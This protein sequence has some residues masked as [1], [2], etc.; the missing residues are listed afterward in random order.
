MI[1]ERDL[2]SDDDA[3]KEP[4]ARVRVLLALRWHDWI[5]P[6]EL[7]DQLEVARGTRERDAAMTALSRLTAQ[8]AVERR[9]FKNYVRLAPN[10]AE[11]LR[12]AQ[13]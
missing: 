8:G 5:E 7:Y 4:N 11:V 2:I 6:E 1:S 3:R 9:G 13:A 12:R 10:A